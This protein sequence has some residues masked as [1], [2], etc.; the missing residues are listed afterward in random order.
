MTAPKL[1]GI[2]RNDRPVRHPLSA[3]ELNNLNAT[4]YA[5]GVPVTVQTV[6]TTLVVLW[7]ALALTTEQQVHAVR[8]VTA[9]TDATVRWAGAL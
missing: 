3:M 1:A 9:R 4:L 8:L 7:P 5:D 6:G 2:C